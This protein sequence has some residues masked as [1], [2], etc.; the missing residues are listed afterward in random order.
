LHFPTEKHDLCSQRV[1][2]SKKTRVI[3]SNSA[4]G[5]GKQLG[6]GSHFF[7]SQDRRSGSSCPGP[8]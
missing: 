3:S 7:K 8:H 6:T 5:E 2:K 4:G 1:T